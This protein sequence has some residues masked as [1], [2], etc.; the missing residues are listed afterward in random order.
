MERKPT[1]NLLVQGERL[2]LEVKFPTGCV[3]TGREEPGVGSRP[4][5]LAW[6]SW[7]NGIA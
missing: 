5:S 1:R 7:A 6:L 2:V 3:N 4:G